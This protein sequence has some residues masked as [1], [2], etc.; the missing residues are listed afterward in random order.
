[1]KEG[2]RIVLV[3]FSRGKPFS[4]VTQGSPGLGCIHYDFNWC[5]RDKMFLYHWSSNSL[6]LEHPDGT[7]WA[8]A[9]LR[10]EDIDKRKVTGTRLTKMPGKYPLEGLFSLGIEVDAVWCKKCRDFLP[11]VDMIDICDHVHWCEKH[12]MWTGPGSDD[13]CSCVKEAV[14]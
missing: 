1:M 10:T 12:G 8:A 6:Y 14:R 3:E 2:H 13:P 7:F 5:R 9:D 11:D 4:V